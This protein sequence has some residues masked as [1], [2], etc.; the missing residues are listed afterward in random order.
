MG[1][2]VY[3]INK[4]KNGDSISPPILKT[5]AEKK[6]VF[7]IPVIKKDMGDGIIEI[8]ERGYVYEHSK[9]I[10]ELQ[11]L[12]C[13]KDKFFFDYDW[14]D[15][16][17]PVLIESKHQEKIKQLKFRHAFNDFKEKLYSEFNIENPLH[18]K[19]LLGVSVDNNDVDTMIEKYERE[20][21]PEQEYYLKP[22][23]IKAFSK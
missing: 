9:S 20:E 10:K 8:I 4:D 22:C 16:E 23:Q 14:T 12:Y 17:N 18:K 13:A 21:N 2:Y 11:T 6:G 7:R 19:F 5:I 15:P 1:A 3:I